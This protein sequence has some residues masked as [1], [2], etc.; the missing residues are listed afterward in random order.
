MA[1]CSRAIAAFLMVVIMMPFMRVHAQDTAAA[2]QNP[3]RPIDQLRKQKIENRK[4]LRDA[5]QEYQ[6][7]TQE[8]RGER[9]EAIEDIHDDRRTFMKTTV[10]ERRLMHDSMRG[11]LHAAS[12]TEDKQAIL[13]Q[14]RAD[15][16]AFRQGVKSEVEALRADFR[17]KRSDFHSERRALIADRFVTVL[18]RLTNT[19]DRFEQILSRVDARIEKL[20]AAG[21]NVDTAVSASADAASAIDTADATIA[22]A[23]ASIEAA[24]AADSVKD[25]MEAVR[26]VIHAAIDAAQTAHNDLKE[27]INVLRLL[28]P[29]VA[30]MAT[31]STP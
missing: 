19:I 25:Q 27:L 18:T 23:K 8:F 3:P 11:A 4:E 1:Q 28:S 29:D 30:D 24:A 2:S 6:A 15:R 22:E 21:V 10:E 31:T 14:A 20:K 5:R 7:D 12:S 16:A 26:A 17:E 13:E 9:R